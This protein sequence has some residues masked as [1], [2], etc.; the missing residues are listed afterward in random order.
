[1]TLERRTFTRSLARR[2]SCLAILALALSGCGKTDAP[3][4]HLNAFEMK[5]NEVPPAQQAEIALALEAMFGTPDEPF[6]LP[7]TGLDLKKLQLA[8]GPVRKDEQGADLG[9]YRKH[10]VH[11]HGISGDGMGPTAAILNPY[12]RDYRPGIY[13]FK[14]TERSARPTDED[15][16]RI[17]R[18]GVMSTAMPSFDL[19]LNDEIAALVEYVKY[20]S[21][22]G[23][24]ERS[25]IAAVADLG[26][27]EGLKLDHENLVEENLALVVK[28]W[29]SA[30]KQVISPPAAPPDV[31]AHLAR[32]YNTRPEANAQA[33]P[34][35]EVAAVDP[36]KIGRE[37]FFGKAGC[38]KCH[39]ASAL[40]DGQLTDF[41][42][43][44][45]P[46]QEAR[47]ANRE[48]LAALGQDKNLSPVDRAKKMAELT[49][50]AELLEHDTLPPIN[51]RPRN[52]RQPY[53][54]FGRRPLDLY[55]RLHAGVN[56]AP[57]P[58][59]A[60]AA[61]GATGLTPEEIWRL[62]DYVMSLP[63][64]SISH[65]PAEAPAPE[66]SQM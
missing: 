39:G 58:G 64:E 25:L 14:S 26:E 20:L 48:A 56:G 10:C 29:T 12:P 36:E 43:W 49:A 37:L 33:A 50:M 62:V 61:P 32:M 21:M 44:N 17:V 54:R 9:L 24:V 57:M 1:M 27:N 2:L 28:G 22:R 45:K 4:F 40:G 3:Q 59:I 23:Q 15:L 30:K 7:S 53:Y 8:A 52:L 6:A 51:I 34:S 42:D 31:E 41:D 19:L 66:R 38:A 60:Q 16:T 18:E 5:K 11:C 55:R 65:A 46:I 63:Y 47:K 13:K 35:P